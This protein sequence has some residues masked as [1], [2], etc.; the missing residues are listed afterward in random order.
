MA[1]EDLSVTGSIRLSQSIMD[2][3]KDPVYIPMDRDPVHIPLPGESPRPVSDEELRNM[4]PEPE[5]PLRRRRMGEQLQ[6]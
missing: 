6:G 2:K 1:L 4:S 3:L 5:P